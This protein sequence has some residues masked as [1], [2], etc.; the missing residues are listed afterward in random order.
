MG[1]IMYD[2]LHQTAFDELLEQAVK[3]NK[4]LTPEITEY[5]NYQSDYYSNENE[6][7]LGDY[8]QPS[9][10]SYRSSYED[11]YDGEITEDC[12]KDGQIGCV[13]QILEDTG[14]G[15]LLGLFTK[16]LFVLI[17]NFF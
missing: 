6:A 12:G 11:H 10:V 13:C 8:A 5:D 9:K 17:V 4:T 3:I 14:L 2:Q 7:Y 1:V 15:K 16:N